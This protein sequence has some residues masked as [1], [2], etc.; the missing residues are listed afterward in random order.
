MNPQ[1]RRRVA[2]PR[3]VGG[4]RKLPT[5]I[6]RATPP[7]RQDRADFYLSEPGKISET[8]SRGRPPSS[9][10]RS[11]GALFQPFAQRNLRVRWTNGPTVADKAEIIAS[12]F[13]CPPLLRGQELSLLNASSSSAGLRRI[14]PDVGEVTASGG[15][16]PAPRRTGFVVQMV[17]GNGGPPS[18]TVSQESSPGRPRCRCSGLGGI[19]RRVWT[20]SLLGH[21]FGD[22]FAIGHR[23]G[24]LFGGVIGLGG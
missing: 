13:P 8:I 21:R 17:G 3:G 4:P 20:L 14:S 15:R 23:F 18:C 9:R 12:R 22:S 19:H 5:D 1:Q 7:G 11:R 24:D 6:A 2:T 16:A 10:L